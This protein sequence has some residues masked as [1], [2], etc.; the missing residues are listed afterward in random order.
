MKKRVKAK[1]A[2]KPTLPERKVARKTA[3]AS[4]APKAA[5]P[6]PRK[7][8]PVEENNY[9]PRNSKPGGAA[10]A[11]TTPVKSSDDQPNP[12]AKSARPG[13][14][15]D[16]AMRK[17]SPPDPLESSP[18]SQDPIEFPEETAPKVK[19]YLTAK[20]LREF[21]A[22]LL[23]KRGELAGDVERLTSEALKGKGQG[24]SDQSTM[25]IHMADLGSDNW[26]Q[27]FTIGLIAN[28]QNLVREID[29]ALVRIEDKTYGMCLATGEQISL[30]RL[31]AKPWAKYCIEYERARE[32]GR[33][34]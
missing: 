28:E 25:P 29:D 19:T 16:G 8:G 14:L 9:A 20:Q 12:E 15:Q 3:A 23:L 32:E 2:L 5:I 30:A 31:Q 18:T 34:P 1:V 26:E 22:M 10:V 7:A 13:T 6:A 33:A 11:P 21:K 24:Y 17:A 4:T 27:D